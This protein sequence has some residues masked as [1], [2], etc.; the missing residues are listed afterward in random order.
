[1]APV[2][3]SNPLAGQFVD[4]ING[5]YIGKV[6]AKHSNQH[7]EQRARHQRRLMPGPDRGQ[8]QNAH[9]VVD[10]AFEALDLVALAFYL[11]VDL[12]AGLRSFSE[13]VA[14][15]GPRCSRKNSLGGTKNGFS[16]RIP[17]MMIIGC[18]R[19]M[20][21]TTSPPKF[22]SSYTQTTGSSDGTRL[23][24][25]SYS[26]TQSTSTRGSSAHSMCITKPIPPNPSPSPRP[27]IPCPTPPS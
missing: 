26:S 7:V 6:E 15:S 5:P 27:P 23:T 3:R 2:G 13:D 14:G 21:T 11:H 25:A 19:M 10:A 17:P 20:S 24:R 18:V 16:W 9:Q 22:G 4:K 12:Y 1:M 8:C